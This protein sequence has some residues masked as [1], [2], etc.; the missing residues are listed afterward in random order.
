MSVSNSI[1][2]IGRMGKDPQMEYKGQDASLP[3]TKVSVAADRSRSEG[4]D[5]FN[6]VAFRQ[7]AEFLNE[8]GSKGRLLAIEGE[9]R[10]NRWQDDDENWHERWELIANDVRFLDSPPEKEPNQEQEE[11]DFV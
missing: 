6:V 4:T 9:M 1:R 11:P 3:V 2:I 7:T 10:Q 8:Y 5:W